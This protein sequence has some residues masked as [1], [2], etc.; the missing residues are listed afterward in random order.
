M[1]AAPSIKKTRTGSDH[2]FLISSVFPL[3]PEGIWSGVS[4]GPS[5]LEICAELIGRLCDAFLLL[6][7][8]ITNQSNSDLE[9]TTAQLLKKNGR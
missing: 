2:H 7:I 3:N 4:T 5:L 9:M 6:P 8:V 1:I